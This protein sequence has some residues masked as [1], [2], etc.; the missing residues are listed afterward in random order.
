MGNILLSILGV[1]FIGAVL[2]FSFLNTCTYDVTKDVER[3]AEEDTYREEREYQEMSVWADSSTMYYHCDED[4]KGVH[5]AYTDEMP[6][7]KAEQYG[8]KAC[9]F[10]W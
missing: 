8:Y 5:E 9:Q 10:C 6:L 1:C 7:Y 2:V 4:C 3:K